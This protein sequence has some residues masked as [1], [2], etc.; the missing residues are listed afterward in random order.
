MTRGERYDTASGLKL[1]PG[2]YLG[3]GQHGQTGGAG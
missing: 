1:I 2:G 3:H